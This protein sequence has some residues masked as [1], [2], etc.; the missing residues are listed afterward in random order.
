V[1]KSPL[2]LTKR[3][4][5]LGVPLGRKRTDWKK[6]AM[7]GASAASSVAGG[8]GAKRKASSGMDKGKEMLDKVT[9]A[10][11]QAGSL[12]KA[13]SG[14]GS[15]VGKVTEAAKSM[16]SGGSGSDDGRNVMK[17]RMIIRET[18]EVG[19]PKTVAYNQWTQFTELPSI[20]KGVDSVDQEDDDIVEWTA[21]IGPSRRTWKAEITEQVPDEKIAWQSKDGPEN[22]GVI[23]FHELDAN[24]TL[25]AVE[26]EYFP[27]GLVEKF[28]NIFLVARRRVRKDLRLF[29][30]YIE[31]AGEE[32]GAWRGEISKDDEEL[33]SDAD[34]QDDDAR[35]EDDSEDDE[36]DLTDDEREDANA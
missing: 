6:V 8:L 15:P 2:N 20:V 17:L 25:V 4:K 34:E 26:M 24:L 3:S 18:I 23:S 30:H 16:G 29:K 10:T 35:A 12:G 32:T 13:M 36:I 5:V 28:G 31:L 9:S 1:G 7:L 19:V 22:R 14:A 33:D 11:D 21:K 27:S